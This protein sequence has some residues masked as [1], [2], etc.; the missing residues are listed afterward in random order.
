MTCSIFARV[1]EKKKGR[2]KLN[3]MENSDTY[4]S[5]RNWKKKKRKL[6][7]EDLNFALAAEKIK[8]VFGRRSP[9]I[10]LCYFHQ[11]HSE[12]I[13]AV[14]MPR[15]SRLDGKERFSFRPLDSTTSGNEMV[16]LISFLCS[17]SDIFFSLLNWKEQTRRKSET[18]LKCIWMDKMHF[19]F[20]QMFNVKLFE[21]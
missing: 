19:E 12:S 21:E 9:S 4:I 14:D 20:L 2:K 1:C 3:K 7:S 6:F 11:S 18:V 10:N 8:G 5:V 16:H 13:I 17:F 15:P